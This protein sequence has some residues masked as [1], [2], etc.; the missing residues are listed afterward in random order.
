MCRLLPTHMIA[1]VQ[2]LHRID[3][4]VHLAA[5]MRMI[6]SPL[7]HVLH[8]PQLGTNG[9]VAGAVTLHSGSASPPHMKHLFGACLFF[10][11][12]AL[13]SQFLECKFDWWGKRVTAGTDFPFK[14]G[15]ER[16][17]CATSLSFLLSCHS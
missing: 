3:S 2:K 13:R 8:K 15:S 14:P 1:Q 5:D 6:R 11:D 4:I 10:Q 7:D 16:L 12:A 17:V 9:A